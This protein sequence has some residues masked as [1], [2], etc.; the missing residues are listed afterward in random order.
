MTLDPR[1]TWPFEVQDLYDGDKVAAFG[2]EHGHII[3][4]GPNWWKGDGS[5]EQED[6]ILDS[7]RNAID[8]ARKQRAANLGGE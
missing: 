1:S 8:R 2:V 5:P 3:C 6:R 7:L 4:T